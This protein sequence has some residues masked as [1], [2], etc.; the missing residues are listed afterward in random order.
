AKKRMYPSSLFI[1]A[2]ANSTLA[3]QKRDHGLI[4]DTLHDL[5]TVELFAGDTPSVKYLKLQ[6][7]LSGYH[8]ATAIG[9]TEVANQHLAELSAC[10]EHAERLP[11]S[12]R[13]ALYTGIA[14]RLL[15]QPEK[16][17]AYARDIDWSDTFYVEFPAAWL[18]A[19]PN[20]PVVALGNFEQ[21]K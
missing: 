7:H 18:Y 11:K 4:V 3:L 1:R 20:D 10:L 16:A 17:F 9:K 8:V 15:N 14:H 19:E 13:L 2:I 5:R 21:L 12:P 6:S